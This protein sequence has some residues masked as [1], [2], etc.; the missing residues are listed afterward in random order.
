[1]PTVSLTSYVIAS[2]SSLI[3]AINSVC[4]PDGRQPPSNLFTALYA[5][6]DEVYS[7]LVYD[8]EKEAV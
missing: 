3:T 6:R 7:F 5:A 2:N 8:L 1:M 4:L